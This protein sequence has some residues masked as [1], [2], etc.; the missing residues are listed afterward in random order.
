MGG[1][2]QS[3]PPNAWLAPAHISLQAQVLQQGMTDL[4][5]SPG[6]GQRVESHFARSWISPSRYGC[7][8]APSHLGRTCPQQHQPCPSSPSPHFQSTGLSA[9]LT[10]CTV[11]SSGGTNLAAV[12]ES[13]E[14]WRLQITPG[15]VTKKMPALSKAIF[16]PACPWDL[17]AD[18]CPSYSWLL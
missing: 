16:H 1:I 10:P 15:L 8:A 13:K 2:T 7:E 11:S 9:D 17:L 6:D 4:L 12:T 18:F 14:K 3:F 5:L